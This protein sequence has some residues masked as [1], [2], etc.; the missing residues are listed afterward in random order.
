MNNPTGPNAPMGPINPGMSPD[1]ERNWAVAAHLS[2]FAAAYVALGFL[3]PLVVMLLIGD[4]S[5]FAR[6][7]AVDALNFNLS[8][9]IYLA[10]SGVLVFIIIGIPMLIALGIAYLVLVIMGAVAASKGAEF[11]YPLSIR[12]VS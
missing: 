2:S 1:S 11:R 10:V 6:R 8:W 12:F 3:G 4:R 5:P 9:L 7:H